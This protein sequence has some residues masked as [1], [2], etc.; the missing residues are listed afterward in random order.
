M[1]DELIQLIHPGCVRIIVQLGERQSGGDFMATVLPQWIE[2]L[3]S[4][5]SGPMVRGTEEGA[6]LAR[7]MAFDAARLE[8]WDLACISALWIVLYNPDP[9]RMTMTDLMDLADRG[10][11]RITASADGNIWHC[12][13]SE[14]SNAP[15]AT[16][17]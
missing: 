12:E 1:A 14:Y 16:I 8:E 6:E 11:I 2:S 4:S 9:A 13:V 7:E 5:A 15:D 17:H 3:E 10:V